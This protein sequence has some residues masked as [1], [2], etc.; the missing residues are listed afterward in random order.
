MP[1]PALEELFASCEPM[2]RVAIVKLMAEDL[3]HAESFTASLAYDGARSRVLAAL[4]EFRRV[5]ERVIGT[6]AGWEFPFREK[7]SPNSPDSVLKG[8]YKRSRSSKRTACSR[9]KGVET[10]EL[11]RRQSGASA[12]IT[13]PSDSLTRVRCSVAAFSMC[14]SVSYQRLALFVLHSVFSILLSACSTFS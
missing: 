8:S 11:I 3:E 12:S 5:R 6:L 4:A 13:V 10:R 1:R 14:E 2:F 7:S 9:S